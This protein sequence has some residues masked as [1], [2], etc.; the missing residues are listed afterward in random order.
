LR[1]E[2]WK[3]RIAIYV[4]V[5][6]IFDWNRSSTVNDNPYFNYSDTKRVSWQARTLRFGLIFKLGRMELESAQAGQ[7]QGERR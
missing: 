6:D 2:F 4:N 7:G 3:H 1:A 5:D